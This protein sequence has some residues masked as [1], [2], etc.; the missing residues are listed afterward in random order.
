MSDK[1]IERELGDLH[2]RTV[3]A[4]LAEAKANRQCPHCL[5]W[6][7]S[8]PQRDAHVAKRHGGA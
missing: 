6:F 7:M 2:P 4:R 8:K 3:D 1:W 5:K